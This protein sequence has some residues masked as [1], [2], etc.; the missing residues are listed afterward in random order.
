MDQFP[1]PELLQAKY[2]EWKGLTPAQEAIIDTSYYDD[3]TESKIPTAIKS[4]SRRIETAYEIYLGLYQAITGANGAGKSNLI[5]FSG[6][7]MP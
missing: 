6:C 3:G 1:S 7:F 5:S 4:K 2:N